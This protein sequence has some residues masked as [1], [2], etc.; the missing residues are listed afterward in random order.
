MDEKEKLIPLHGGYR[1]LKSFQVAQLAY[2]VTV[3][4]CELGFAVKHGPEI[5]PGELHA[6]RTGFSETVLAK[7]L[8]DAPRMHSGLS[9]EVR[10]PAVADA[11]A[12]QAGDVNKELAKSM[13]RAFGE[14]AKTGEDLLEKPETT[15]ML[16]QAQHDSVGVG[17]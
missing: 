17:T 16:R 9:G 10:L 12:R 8:R 2:D 3:R 13:Q 15:E 6:E 1:K 14:H 5:A 7:R 11:A 4:F